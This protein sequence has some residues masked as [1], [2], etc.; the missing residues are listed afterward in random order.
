MLNSSS[1]GLDNASSWFPNNTE[2]CL[3]QQQQFK[4]ERSPNLKDGW[5][6]QT[7]NFDTN[8]IKIDQD[9]RKILLF[10]N[11]QTADIRAAILNI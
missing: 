11:F 4:R 5:T 10:E 7:M 1:R 3:E 8:L 2:D 6:S 9:M